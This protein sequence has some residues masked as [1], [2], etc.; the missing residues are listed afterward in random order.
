[1]HQGLALQVPPYRYAH[2]DDLAAL[3]A[4][5]GQVPLLVALDSVTDPRNLGAVLRCAAAFGA[6]GVVIPERRSAGMSAGAWKASAGAATRVRVA[7]ATN[8]TRQLEAYRSAGYAVVGLSADGPVSAADLEVAT[9]PLVL[10]VGSEDQGLSRL[11]ERAC[12]V[13]VS[14]PMAS[15]TES[16]NAGVA[17]GIVLYEVARRRSAG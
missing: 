16:L 3:A 17:A 7:R 1:V 10:V 6:H 5:S 14:I 15:G 9:G 8:L 4:D 13:L 12:D 11:V 2:P